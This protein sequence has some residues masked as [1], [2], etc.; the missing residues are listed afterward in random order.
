MIK[1][2]KFDS[3][4][5]KFKICSLIEKKISKKIL[6][7]NLNNAKKKKVDLLYSELQKSNYKNINTF[8]SLGF[9]VVDKRN[10]MRKNLIKIKNFYK[11][12]KFK[13]KILNKKYLSQ[14]LLISKNLFKDSRYYNEKKFLKSDVNKIF[15]IWLK[16]SIVK[17]FDD[18]IYGFFLKNKL[19]GFC[20]FKK[21]SKEK[22]KIGLIG[23]KNNYTNKG[24]GAIFMNQIFQNLNVKGYKIIDLI[25]LDRNKR[26]KKFYNKM[27]FDK[28]NESKI[29]QKWI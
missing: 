25:V 15:E 29:L 18:F 1:K 23:L 19:I 21:K 4:L 13:V 3:N 7:K 8:K 26:A 12:D 6:I 11:S 10:F 28:I 27:K 22:I 5:F 9:K 24:Y 17:K 14:L 16:K 2:N 20:T